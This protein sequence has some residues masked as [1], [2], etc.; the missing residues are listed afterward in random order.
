MMLRRGMLGLALFP[1]ATLG[2][3]M[4]RAQAPSGVPA[5]IGFVVVRDGREVGTHTVRFRAAQGLLQARSEVR[6]VVRLAGIPVF[7]Y[8][9]DT[10]EAWR[11]VT[12]NAARA[13]GL[14]DRGRLAPGLR[15]DLALWDAAH[16]RELAYRFGHNPGRSAWVAGVRRA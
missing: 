1:G 14:G 7:R 2:P 8:S 4:A 13:L 3:G 6:I 10:E 15:A 11:G 16:P 9:H 5:D 12:V